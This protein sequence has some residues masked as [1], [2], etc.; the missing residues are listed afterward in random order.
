MLHDAFTLGLLGLGNS[1]FGD[2]PLHYTCGWLNVRF[3]FGQEW[4]KHKK[5]FLPWQ[6]EQEMCNRIV[7]IENMET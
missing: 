6:D 4:C 1:V 3:C 7:Q 2:A 5:L